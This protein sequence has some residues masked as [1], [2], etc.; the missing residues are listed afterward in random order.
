MK[1]PPPEGAFAIAP[2]E[3]PQ[4]EAA[5]LVLARAFRDNPLNR[6]VI[7]S[8]D[9][10]RRLRCN[11]HGMRT[12]LASAVGFG[13]AFVAIV[14][15]A[16]AGALLAVPPGAYPLPTPSWSRQ[17]RCFVGQGRRVA[18][19]W[20]AVFDLLHGHHPVEPYA[21]LG[22]LGVDPVLHG[23]GVGTALLRHWL[24]RTDRDGSPAYL[25][26]DSESNLGFY[27]RAGFEIAGEILVFG[28]PV[29]RM[30]RPPADPISDGASPQ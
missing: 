1:P 2:L 17:F 8:G 4:R 6:A 25:E 5:I 3:D 21:Y 28:T 23:R 14:D 13:E 16:V 26:T 7:E 11:L 27:S 19:R 29:W 22:T 12:S 18:T 15:G 30:H 24:A 10:G 9:S 20:G